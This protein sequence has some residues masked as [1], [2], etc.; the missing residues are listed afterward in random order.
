MYLAR[1]RLSEG[2]LAL[3]T[4]AG[5]WIGI[6][7]AAASAGMIKISK[8]FPVV[9][10]FVAAHLVTAA[11]TGH[12]PR[13]RSHVEPTNVTNDRPVVVSRRLSWY[14]IIWVQLRRLRSL[15]SW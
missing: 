11:I 12:G 7:S 13:A 4:L 1:F 15:A 6:A 14:A 3:D 2:A 8:P 9:G 5:L 10:L